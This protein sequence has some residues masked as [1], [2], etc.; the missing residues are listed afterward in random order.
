MDEGAAKRVTTKR[1]RKRDRVGEMI[2]K[3][4]NTAA[5]S[6]GARKRG[7]KKKI[8]RADGAAHVASQQRKHTQAHKE[9]GRA[10][11]NKGVLRDRSGFTAVYF[12]GTAVLSSS[13]ATT[14]RIGPSFTSPRESKTAAPP[15]EH[16]PRH[17]KKK[18]ARLDT[19]QV[20]LHSYSPF[21][22]LGN[23]LKE[24]PRGVDTRA[25]KPNR[26]DRDRENIQDET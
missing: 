21:F 8:A 15:R 16:Q 9:G 22:L 20:S 5:S 12:L 23:F 26:R 3:K 6:G 11:Q 19:L 24:K 17:Q 10:K 2:F 25:M 1:Q 18:K 14:A 4:E 13:T 7:K